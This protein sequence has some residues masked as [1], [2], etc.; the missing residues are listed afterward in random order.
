M[1]HVHDQGKSMKPLASGRKPGQQQT[2]SVVV[3]CIVRYGAL[4]GTLC[5]CYDL[6]RDFEARIRF[7]RQVCM[8]QALEDHKLIVGSTMNSLGQ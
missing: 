7:R 6:R 1:Q 5:S 2:V 4:L 3:G 8:L